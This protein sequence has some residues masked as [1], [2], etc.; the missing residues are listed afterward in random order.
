MHESYK[1]LRLLPP[2][3]LADTLIGLLKETRHVIYHPD[4]SNA[5][6]LIGMA[7]LTDLIAH[8]P[9]P[10]NFPPGETGAGEM[11][12][13]EGT[14]VT[15]SPAPSPVGKLFTIRASRMAGEPLI[16]V[17]TRSV[18]DAADYEELACRGFACRRDGHLVGAE[19]GRTFAATWSVYVPRRLTLPACI[20]LAETAEPL[21]SVLKPLGVQREE[22][23]SDDGDRSRALLWLPR[24]PRSRVVV[25]L[26]REKLLC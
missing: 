7:E 13:P 10:E 2:D 20:R 15:H 19:T 25:A 8:Y 3:V 24:G 21:G 12:A 18:V 14:T 6:K 16:A 9:L 17:V 26:A 11:L 22:L 1:H 5:A 4:M 23:K